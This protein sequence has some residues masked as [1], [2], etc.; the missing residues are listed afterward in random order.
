MFFKREHPLRKSNWSEETR[1]QSY[2]GQLYLTSN[3]SDDEDA[4]KIKASLARSQLFA[5]SSN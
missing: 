3:L 1:P 5:V 4:R 2:L